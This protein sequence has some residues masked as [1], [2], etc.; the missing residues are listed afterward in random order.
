MAKFTKHQIDFSSHSSLSVIFETE[1]GES[2]VKI[3]S[4]EKDNSLFVIS[5]E[6]QEEFLKDLEKL[7]ERYYI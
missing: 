6:K 1:F 7:I 5:S 3:E 2:K 4:H